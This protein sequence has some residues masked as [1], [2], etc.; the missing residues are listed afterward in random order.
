MRDPVLIATEG[1]LWGSVK[2]HRLR[3]HHVDIGRKSRGAAPRPQLRRS[4]SKIKQPKG[5]FFNPLE[6]QKRN[7][8]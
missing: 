2:A 6:I 8:R 3:R 1:A 7:Y 5:A 4:N